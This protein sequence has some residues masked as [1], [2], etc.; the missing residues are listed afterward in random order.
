MVNIALLWYFFIPLFLSVATIFIVRKLMP[1]RDISLGQIVGFTAGGMLISMLIMTSAF[2]AGKGSKTSDT[3]ILNGEVVKK[4]RIH[5]SYVR[6]YQCNCYTTTDSDGHSTEHCSTCYEDHYTVDWKCSTN[7]GSYTIKALDETSKRVY[8]SP[9]PQRWLIIKPGDPVSATHGYTNYIKAVPE[10]LFNPVSSAQREKYKALIPAYPDRIYDFYHVDRVIPIGIPVSNIREWNDKLSE[11]L[12]KLGPARQANAVIVLT[13]FTDDGFY[14][15]L[16]DAW[17]N[18]K[19]ND[20]VVVIGASSFPAKADWVRIMALTKDEIF[21]VSLRDRILALPTLTADGVIGA[22]RD[23]G[24]ATFK[25]KSMKDF[26]YL[27]AEIDP[28]AWVMTTCSILI[29]LAYF[30]FWIFTYVNRGRANSFN[31]YGMPRLRRY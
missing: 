31:S 18:G 7:I 5:D 1:D 3:E 21:Q 30:G 13:K 23:E 12:K 6:S 26:K 17:K 4:D 11:V 27:E 9:D 10:T 24:F 28:P 16:Q 20:I 25:R 15:A 8:K 19:K 14:F 2:Y 22:V 29:A